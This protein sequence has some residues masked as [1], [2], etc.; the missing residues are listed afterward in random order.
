[1]EGNLTIEKLPQEVTLKILRY[2]TP[3]E[4]H[5]L[6]GNLQSFEP[7]KTTKVLIELSFRRLYSGKTL[8]YSTSEGD[9]ISHRGI[10]DVSLKFREFL[11]A[12]EYPDYQQKELAQFRLVRPQTL[13]FKFNR[14]ANDYTIFVA[15]LYKFASMVDLLETSRGS[16]VSQY[17]KCVHQ[18]E[19][20]INGNSILIETPSSIVVSILKTLISIAS[21]KNP[22]KDRFKVLLII[23]TDIGDYFITQWFQVFGR[24]AN[25][26]SLDLSDNM[27]RSARFNPEE[28]WIKCA[29]WPPRLKSLF[30]DKNMITKLTKELI[31]S[32]PTLLETLLI[33]KNLL[34]V[35]G[36]S[37]EF[38][39]LGK[40][41]P[42]LKYLNLSD[43]RGLKFVNPE[44]F[45]GHCKLEV[46]NLKGCYMDRDNLEELRKIS[47]KNEFRLISD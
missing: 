41:L 19:L 30:L 9:K 3:K 1:M 23:C 5:G 25:L 47:L 11:D 21:K 12:I 37:D 39:E 26:E 32:F 20:H 44:I 27:I 13:D 14:S 31:I 28:D 16:N 34:V 42:N 18:L 29:T 22:L 10:T 24:F 40:G 46:L 2:L 45:D 8:I 7:S 4:T 33:S 17:F 6:I 38:F 43:N 36:Y 15:D 35:V